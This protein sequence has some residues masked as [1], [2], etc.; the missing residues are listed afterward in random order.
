KN[1]ID[2][3]QSQA[4]ATDRQISEIN[5]R[6]NQDGSMSAQE[7]NDYFPQKDAAKQ[8]E[9]QPKES[10]D[11]ASV[12]DML[13]CMSNPDKKDPYDTVRQ[14]ENGFAIG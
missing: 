3:R 12:L 11:L 8:R 5:S 13:A 7:A 9:A 14:T 4:E 1:A 6:F 2:K 10:T